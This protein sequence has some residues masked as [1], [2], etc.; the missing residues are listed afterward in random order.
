MHLIPTRRDI[1]VG[2]AWNMAAHHPKC[3]RFIVQLDSDDVYSDENTLQKF[4][5][6]FHEQQCAMVIGS[7][8]LTD[9]DKNMLPPGK[10]DHREWTPDNGRNNAL[11]ING[12]GAPRGFFTPV[13]RAIN[14][15]NVNYGEDYAL[16]LAISR[17]YQIGRIY[18]VLYC[19]RR[20]DDNSDA[21][22]SIEKENRN[23]TYKDRVR[24]W[25][26]QAR[27]AMNK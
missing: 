19:C 21:A 2:G 23:N 4:V 20:W 27:I 13:V 10:I 26:L 9:I 25:E 7:Y 8:M 18:D 3:G 6:A 16:G 11:R 14:L 24:T 22:L 1:G 15:P 12:L 17:R 5:D